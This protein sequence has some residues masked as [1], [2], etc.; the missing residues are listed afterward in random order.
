MGGLCAWDMRT[1]N[2]DGWNDEENDA[3]FF[4]RYLMLNFSQ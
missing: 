3:T 4:G 1:S 2:D